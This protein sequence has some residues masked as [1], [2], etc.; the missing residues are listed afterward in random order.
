MPTYTNIPRRVN[1]GSPVDWIGELINLHRLPNEDLQSFKLRVLDNYIHPATVHYN[2]L[3]NGMGREL[4]QNNY[5]GGIVIDLERVNDVP[6]ADPDTIVEINSRGLWLGVDPLSKEFSTDGIWDI[7]TELKADFHDRTDSYHLIDLLAN[8]N[9][10]PGLEAVKFGTASDWDKS[11]N[12]K[13]ATSYRFF[14]KSVQQGRLHTFYNQLDLGNFV[15]DI[16]W[17]TETGIYMSVEALDDLADCAEY[18]IEP[19]DRIAHTFAIPPNGI[20]R[21]YYSDF[22]LIIPIS[23]VGIRALRDHHT[24]NLYTEQNLDEFGELQDGIPTV[25]GADF[26]NELFSVVPQ[27]W[28]E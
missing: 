26:V 25:R 19:F 16:V 28:G 7:N 11:K 1:I 12:L 3:Y 21:V 10:I 13:Q 14:D 23:P 2:G 6:T 8:I 15:R 17:S 27:Y 5:T 24:M 18:F 22:P 9:A 4:G 20:A